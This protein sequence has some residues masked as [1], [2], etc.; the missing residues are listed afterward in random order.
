MAHPTTAELGDWP[1]RLRADGRSIAWL[2][3][4]L[5]VQR[6]YL[7]AVASGARR[8]SPTLLAR[9]ELELGP[10]RLEGVGA[11]ASGR[12]AFLELRAA[13]EAELL[14]HGDR[15]DRGS[16]ELADDLARVALRTIGV[17]LVHLAGGYMTGSGA[18]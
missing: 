13:I 14:R 17:E 11:Y 16:A 5:G 15:D 3:E 9:I 8:A 1:A 6:T 18:S 10:P 4:R 12:A 2:A 7:S